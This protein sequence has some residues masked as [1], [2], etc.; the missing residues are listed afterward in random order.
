MAQLVPIGALGLWAK[1]QFAKRLNTTGFQHLALTWPGERGRIITTPEQIAREP[2]CG[3]I[4]TT[5]QEI[6]LTPDLRTWSRFVTVDVRAASV[7]ALAHTI[8]VS[9]ALALASALFGQVQ[10]RRSA[11]LLLRLQRTD[12]D[13]LRYAPLVPPN[14]KRQR[15]PV[16]QPDN[17][18][19]HSVE[20]VEAIR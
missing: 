18:N 8:W 10:H 7:F 17:G 12:Q 19:H 14:G 9:L 15:P 13:T 3:Q 5:A 1:Y 2:D 11:P 4:I 16:T 6:A 20:D